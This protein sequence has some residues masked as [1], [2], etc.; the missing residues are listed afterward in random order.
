MKALESYLL[1]TG[2]SGGTIHQ[3]V[4]HLESLEIHDLN[5]S[6]YKYGMRDGMREQKHTT[7]PDVFV[8]VA[9]CGGDSVCILSFLRGV[10]DGQKFAAEGVL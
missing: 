10:L 8:P 2:L 3:A 7:S 5:Q 4:N 6:M 9:T 1:A